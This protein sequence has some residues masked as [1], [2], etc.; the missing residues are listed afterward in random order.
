V[1]PYVLG[2]G[3]PSLLR[4]RQNVSYYSTLQ[5]LSNCVK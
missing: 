3:K 1:G 4:Q 2:R 5:S